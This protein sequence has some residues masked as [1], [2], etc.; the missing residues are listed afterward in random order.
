MPLTPDKVVNVKVG[1][2]TLKISQ[3]IIPDSLVATKYVASWVG[4]GDKMKPCTKLGGDGKA[5]G[6]TIHNTSTITV[7]NTTMAEQYTRATYNGN[8]AGVVVSYYVSGYS[9]IW[10][11]LNTDYGKAEAG[12]HASDGLNRKSGHSGA[13]YKSLGGNVDTIAIECIGNSAEAE[14]AVARLAAYLCKQHKLKPKL[15]V[16]THNYWMGYG[17]KTKV[18]AP[19]NCPIYI[20]PHWNEFVDKVQKYYDELTKPTPATPTNGTIYRVQVGAFSVKSNA[21]KLAKELQSKGY[22]T[23]IKTD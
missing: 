9:D 13:T 20:L 8:M 14:D 17:D 15:D 12:W 5:R 3:K 2:K 6:I 11:N 21:E 22:S 7:N 16:Y 4:K 18:G 10:Q 19:K 23:I 1:D